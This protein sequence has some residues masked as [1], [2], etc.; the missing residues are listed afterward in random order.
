MQVPASS[1]QAPADD[2]TIER[3]FRESARLVGLPEELE[4]PAA[5]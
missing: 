3:L 2:A 1:V 4:A 5:G